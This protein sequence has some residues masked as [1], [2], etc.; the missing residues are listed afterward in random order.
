[1]VMYDDIWTGPWMKV[2]PFMVRQKHNSWD[3]YKYYRTELRCLAKDYPQDQ[4]KNNY[5]YGYGI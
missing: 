2:G 4:E 5:S 1:M 3:S